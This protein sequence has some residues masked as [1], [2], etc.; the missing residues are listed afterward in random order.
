MVAGMTSGQRPSRRPLAATAGVLAALRDLVLA[1]GCA[2][3]GADLP[4]GGGALLCPPCR[5]DLSGPPRQAWPTPAPPG[6][7]TPWAVAD[8][9]GGVRGAVLAHKEDGRL[10]LARPLGD[11]LALAVEAAL[12]HDRASATD[13]RLPA[14][15][16]SP[17]VTLVPVPSRRSAVRAR[18]HDATLRLA[19]RAAT[20][21]RRAG[22]AVRVL[23]V[24]RVARRLAD[25]AGLDA[26]QRAANLDGALAVSGAAGRLLDRG[27]VVLVDDVLTTGASLAETARA[28]RAAGGTVV[29]AAVVAATVRRLPPGL[30][31]DRPC[32]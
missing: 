20:T 23:P 27:E 24:V 10:S 12:R 21:L 26:G 17:L 25:Q 11:A 5:R 19:R 14:G 1:S 13:P 8:Y 22:V 2:G 18:G 28:V 7:P 9:A 6:L 32:G 15:P 16:R 31:L 29:A 30:C 3:C 4:G